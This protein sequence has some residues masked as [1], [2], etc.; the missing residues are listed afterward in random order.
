MK[1]ILSLYCILIAFSTF[2]ARVSE[3]KSEDPKRALRIMSYN[4]HHCNPPESAG[5][6]IDVE[7]I[8]K[9][10]NNAKPDFV[11][12]QEV[13]INTERSG[14]GLNQAKQIADL[15]GMKFY[16]S[17]AIDHQGGDYGVAVLSKFPIVD[18]ARFSLPINRDLVEEMR[19]IAAITVMLPS[20][21]KIIFASTHLGLTER[22]RL[23]QA[24][25]IIKYFGEEK[26]P[27]IL[28]GDFNAEPGSKV[29][30]YFDKYFSRTCAESCQHTIPVDKPE[31]TIDFIMSKPSGIF[32]V[33]SHKVIDEKYASDHL[34]VLAELMLVK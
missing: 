15:T 10:I 18:S 20:K 7:A 12:L 25:T 1:S 13:D 30:N 11:A 32:K 24:E 23:L 28:A 33:L 2:N 16:F 6:R 14:K 31:K 19:T 27:M 3:T 26:L 29:I 21:Q 5:G 4:I 34:P 9:V 8:A 17:K 22:N